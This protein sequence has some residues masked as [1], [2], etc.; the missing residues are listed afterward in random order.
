MSYLLDTNVLAE[1][2]KPAPDPRVVT[3]VRAQS[4]LNLFIS[5]VALG[6]IQRG[7]TLIASGA[8][9]TRLT[10]WLRT[11]LPKEFRGRLLVVDDEVARAWGQLNAEGRA[12]GRPLPVLDGLLLAS[13]QVHDLTLVTR[14]VADCADRGHPVFDPWKGVLYGED[15]NGS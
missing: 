14:N 5:V 4:P 9:R 12:S 10:R 3:W 8:R 2:V 15:E 7:V 13:A 11:E 1:L 6:E